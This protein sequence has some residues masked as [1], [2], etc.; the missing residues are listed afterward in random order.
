M[1][2]TLCTRTHGYT[3]SVGLEQMSLQHLSPGSWLLRSGQAPFWDG[4]GA[5]V[6]SGS[7]H[8]SAERGKQETALIQSPACASPLPGRGTGLR[9][10]AAPGTGRDGAGR[11][12]TGRPLSARGAPRTA[13]GGGAAGGTRVPGTTR[14]GAGKFVLAARHTPLPP[15]AA[16]RGLRAPR[17]SGA[18]RRPGQYE[19]AAPMCRHR[20]AGSGRPRQDGRAAARC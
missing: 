9:L 17:G 11:G 4:D 12:G 16:Q 15:A 18:G 7:R 20:A 6:P 5:G 8:P 19:G 10:G 14:G 2:D 13:P 3:R 1:L